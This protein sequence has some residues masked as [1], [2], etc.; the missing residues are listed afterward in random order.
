[1]SVLLFPLPSLYVTDLCC[2]FH[3]IDHGTLGDPNIAILLLIILH[4]AC[5]SSCRRPVLPGGVGVDQCPVRAVEHEV[6]AH[7]EKI[8]RH[9]SWLYSHQIFSESELMRYAKHDTNNSVGR[10]D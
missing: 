2:G 10:K 1:V 4:A 3:D 6:A 5:E 8:T 9:S 7:E